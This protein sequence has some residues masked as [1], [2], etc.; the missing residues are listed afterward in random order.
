MDMTWSEQR[1]GSEHGFVWIHELPWPD[2]RISPP[3]FA[4][5]EE[6]C[7]MAWELLTQVYG[8]PEDRLWVSYF[9]GDSRTGLDPDLETRDIWLSLG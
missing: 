7:S 2:W 4:L 6:A 5:Q 1:V 8:I 3:W 9:S